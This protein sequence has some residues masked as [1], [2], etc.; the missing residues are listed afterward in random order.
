MDKK[1]FTEERKRE[2]DEK[3]PGYHNSSA[4]RGCPQSDDEKGIVFEEDILERSDEDEE[5]QQENTK[6]EH[7]PRLSKLD[8]MENKPQVIEEQYQFQEAIFNEVLKNRHQVNA[9][10]MHQRAR[11]A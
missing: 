9:F 7:F 11:A 2:S 3:C 8:E 4:M 5:V 1:V 6:K 10:T